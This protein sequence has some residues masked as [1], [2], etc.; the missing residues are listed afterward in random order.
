MPIKLSQ[1]KKF[2][3]KELKAIIKSNRLGK[4]AKK[5]KIQLIG[6]ITSCEDCKLIMNGLSLPV[7]TRKPPSAKQ[8]AARARFSA[9]VKGK[10]NKPLIGGNPATFTPLSLPQNDIKMR[11][12]N[13]LSIALQEPEKKSVKVEAIKEIKKISKKIMGKRDFLDSIFGGS[14]FNFQRAMMNVIGEIENQDLL[15]KFLDMSRAKKEKLLLKQFNGSM[16]RI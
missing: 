13:K 7:R 15:G 11:E 5:K 12:Q 14:V 10:K 6:M 3:V 9:M 8:L 4:I 2:N 16:N 1:L